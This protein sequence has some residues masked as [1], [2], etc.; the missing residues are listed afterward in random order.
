MEEGCRKCELSDDEDKQDVDPRVKVIH[1]IF[2]GWRPITKIY[3]LLKLVKQNVIVL[4]F[5]WIK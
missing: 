4:K 5:P 1:A 2:S 3:L